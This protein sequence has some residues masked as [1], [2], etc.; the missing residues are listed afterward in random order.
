MVTQ[1]SC[2]STSTFIVTS[3]FA[4]YLF[5]ALQKENHPDGII[6]NHEFDYILNALKD[7]SFNDQMVGG[8]PLSVRLY[9]LIEMIKAAKFSND[10]FII[11]GSLS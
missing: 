7:P 8:V 5:Q 10:K 3:D 2:S 6:L 9:P 1:F 4:P 11:W